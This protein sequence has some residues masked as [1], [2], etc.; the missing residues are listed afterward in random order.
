[1][2]CIDYGRTVLYLIS[3]IRDVFNTFVYYVFTFKGFWGEDMCS[4]SN[5]FPLLMHLTTR[6]P[7][8]LIYTNSRGS[9][10]RV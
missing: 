10:E 8:T 9:P 7:S 1:M 5:A 3:Y 4:G 2:F 6:L